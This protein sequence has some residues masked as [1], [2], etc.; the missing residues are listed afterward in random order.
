MIFVRLGFAANS[1]LS[2]SAR[3]PN[4]EEFPAYNHFIAPSETYLSNAAVIR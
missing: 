1:V 3:A 4:G 2:D